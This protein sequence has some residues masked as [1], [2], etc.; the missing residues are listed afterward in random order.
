MQHIRGITRLS[1]FTA[2]K[3][4]FFTP[5]ITVAMVGFLALWV[6]WMAWVFGLSAPEVALGFVEEATLPAVGATAKLGLVALCF[7]VV[8]AVGRWCHLQAKL[9]LDPPLLARVL[10]FLSLHSGSNLSL[11]P[12]SRVLSAALT[13]HQ[14]HRTSNRPPTSTSADL[15]GAAPLLN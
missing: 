15:A 5:V 8:A 9:R 3:F 1:W 2:K 7:S 11:N 14:L 4:A 10:R 12:I 6:S 13:G